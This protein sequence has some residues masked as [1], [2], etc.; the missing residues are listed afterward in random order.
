MIQFRKFNPWAIV[1]LRVLTLG[2]ILLV[3]NPDRIIVRNLQIWGLSI[4]GGVEY[5]CQAPIKG[6]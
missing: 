4:G 5:V 1:G 3:K 2:Q 6:I